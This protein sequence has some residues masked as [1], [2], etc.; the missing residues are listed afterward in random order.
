[1]KVTIVG[2]TDVV[3]SLNEIGIQIRGRQVAHN[4]EL[5]TKEKENEIKG[6]ERSGLIEIIDGETSNRETKKPSSVTVL[7]QPVRAGD[8]DG[9]DDITEEEKE[10]EKDKEE[11]KPKKKAKRVPKP[12]IQEPKSEQQEALDAEAET[13]K[14]GSRVIISTGD[15]IVESKMVK[16]AT[17]EMQESKAT[18]ASIEAMDKLEKE[19]AG[20]EVDDVDEISPINEEDLPPEEQMGRGATIIDEGAEKKVDMVNSAVPGSEGIKEREFFIDKKENA[21]IEK[22]R[23]K[24]EDSKTE[25]KPKESGELQASD[26]KSEDKN[27]DVEDIFASDES[28]EDEGVAENEDDT[29]NEDDLFIEW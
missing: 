2:K 28:P 21:E 11:E 20:E 22:A 13:Q 4:V 29:E 8:E 17:G 12:E 15:Q 27:E 9:T 1:M 6:L 7:S 14:E 5:D 16:N 24:N 19:E 25:E 10:G 26:E 23:Q 18:K 3:L